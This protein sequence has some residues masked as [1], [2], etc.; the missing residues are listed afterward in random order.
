MTAKA[1]RGFGL[2]VLLALPAFWAGWQWSVL[3]GSGWSDWLG[4]NPVAASIHWSGLW[5]VRIL[6]VT[7]A[8]SQLTQIKPLA[9]LR[10]HRRLFGLA[11]FAY[12]TTHLLLYVGLD[13]QWHMSAILRELIKRWYLTLGISAW[14]I[15]VPLAITSTRGWMMRLKA[16]WRV[17]HWGIYPAS[18]LAV[19]HEALVRKI[20]STEAA[21]SVAIVVVLTVLRLLVAVRRGLPIFKGR[22]MTNPRTAMR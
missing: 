21:I 18:L 7:L 5:A 9:W 17:L 20:L 1:W 19:T 6:I 3:L 14:L 15:L 11:S 4:A 12:A 13:Q 16:R 10:G 8:L 2:G 22:A